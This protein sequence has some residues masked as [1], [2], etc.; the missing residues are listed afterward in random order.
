MYKQIILKSLLIIILFP[1]QAFASSN[2]GRDNT[3]RGS[4]VQKLQAKIDQVFAGNPRLRETYNKTQNTE[5]NQIRKLPE[6]HDLLGSKELK[7]LNNSPE[8]QENI[9]E[10]FRSVSTEIESINKEIEKISVQTKQLEETLNNQKNSLPQVRTS[11]QDKININNIAISELKKGIDEAIQSI[12]Q[13]QELYFTDT[14]GLTSIGELTPIQKPDTVTTDALL[15]S[16][17]NIDHLI[18][19][20]IDNIVTNGVGVASGD[21]R[22]SAEGL[23]VKGSKSLGKQIEYKLTPGYTSKQGAV[24]LGLD[25]IGDI[26]YLLGVSYS[27]IEDNIST[28]TPGTK[29]KINSHIGNIYG[30]YKFSDNLFIDAHAKYGKSYIKKSRNNLNLSNNISYADTT[31]EIYG[32]KLELGYSYSL[33]DKMHIVPSIGASY[34]K[35]EIEGY[36]EKGAGFNRRINTRRVNKTDALFGIKVVKNIELG[37]YN[38]TSDIHVKVRET[39]NS[40]NDKTVITILEGT[41]PLV[42]P[43]GN[44]PKTIYKMGGSLKITSSQALELTAGYD[45]G[46]SKKYE[47]HTG[48]LSAKIIF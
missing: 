21:E 23:W 9:K 11:I 44:M 18:D 6:Y 31:G 34:D 41:N 39:V 20:I 40:H 17:S 22:N 7:I 5:L 10:A 37:S 29:E 47:S 27:F 33:S 15:A 12:N 26:D 3:N 46:I 8:M 24:T 32:G 4:I 42:T 13:H 25:F 19:T 2:I 30:L 16:I 28:N 48:Y 1:K 36:R 35:F 38:F 43:S 45:L 14:K